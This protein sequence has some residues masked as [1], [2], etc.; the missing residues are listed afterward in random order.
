MYFPKF[1][2]GFGHQFAGADLNRPIAVSDYLA[3]SVRA[4]RRLSS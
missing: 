1:R 2:I 4:L 3:F